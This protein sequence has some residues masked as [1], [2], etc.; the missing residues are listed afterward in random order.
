MSSAT[1][2]A[3]SDHNKSLHAVSQA[4]PDVLPMTPHTQPLINR[5]PCE[6]L[7][8]ILA[9]VSL[10]PEA[11]IVDVTK[12]P[13]TLSYVCSGWRALLLNAG[14]LWSDIDI[15]IS[16]CSPS[17]FSG[18][19][20]LLET[21][22]SRSQNHWLSVSISGDLSISEFALWR[23]LHH[24]ARFRTLEIELRPTHLTLFNSLQ[25]P[26]SDLRN[27]TVRDTTQTDD[28]V[29]IE[30]FGNFLKEAPQLRKV[31]L[32]DGFGE[33][34]YSIVTHCLPAAQLVDIELDD[35]LDP[36]DLFR[37][38]LEACPLLRT[39]SVPRA[40]LDGERDVYPAPI[41][42]ENLTSLII[43]CD[44]SVPREDDVT[45]VGIF[46][47]VTLPSLWTLTFKSK[48]PSHILKFIGALSPSTIQSFID[49]S[50]C[51]ISHLRIDS[52]STEFYS[53]ID[54]CAV[55]PSLEVLEYRPSD[56]M[57]LPNTIFD[58]LGDDFMY[59]LAYDPNDETIL[60][61]NLKTLILEDC[62][63]FGEDAYFPDMVESRYYLS[64]ESKKG[65]KVPTPPRVAKL[66]KVSFMI[67]DDLGP[68]GMESLEEM[69]S[70]GLDVWVG[71]RIWEDEK[72]GIEAKNPNKSELHSIVQVLPRTE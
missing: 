56:P 14:I 13:W 39:L 43:R 45:T 11:S 17:P 6:L 20:R 40:T 33:C 8:T 4:A 22:L 72:A 24:S 34:A 23:I 68:Y 54:I 35:L 51:T 60:L 41:R 21:F 58:S 47:L 12:P 70:H 62:H 46:D 65:S 31:V 66:E 27:F 44:W 71:K 69:M 7:E 5:L 48:W 15:D 49:R 61:P 26:F 2:Q 50:S 9:I 42:H 29:T 3:P 55:I 64:Y 57:G 19:M 1:P 10:S 28:E 53:F 63:G 32:G 59:H 18:E 52:M 30:L 16:D 38:I 67:D 25:H 36:D 37:F